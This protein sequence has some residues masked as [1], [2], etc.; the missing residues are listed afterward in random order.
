MIAGE[1][2]EL[3]Q[4]NPFLVI[5]LWR[6]LVESGALVVVDGAARL[7]RPLAEVASP[8]AVRE[9]VS[10]RLDRLDPV[11]TSVLQLAAVV[12][13]DFDLALIQSGPAGMSRRF[14]RRSIWPS[15]TA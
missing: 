9:V 10:Q 11:T 2:H 13:P 15:R 6:E 3:T 14:W 1:V 7:S 4:G 5:E 12:G 8:E